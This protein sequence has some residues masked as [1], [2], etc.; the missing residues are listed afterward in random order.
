MG[1]EEIAHHRGIGAQT[2]FRDAAISADA[3]TV[4]LSIPAMKARRLYEISLQS[5]RTA[6][7]SALINPLVVYH[8]HN[9]RE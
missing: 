7:G 2:L 1:V 3:M 6:E 4:L 8:A 9:L 5:L